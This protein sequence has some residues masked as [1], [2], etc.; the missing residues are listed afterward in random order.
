MGPLIPLFWTSGDVSYGF[1]NQSGQ[2]YSC[3]VE[4]YVLCIS[5][6]SALVWHLR[7]SW[8]PPWQLNH[9]LP[10]I[11]EQALVGLETG[12]CHAVAASRCETRQTLYLAMSAR[13][14][15]VNVGQNTSWRMSRV[16]KNEQKRIKKTFKIKFDESV[17]F[18]GEVSSFKSEGFEFTNL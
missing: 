17:H 16:K 8:W 9:S 10:H 12:I 2:P 1:Q 13:L 6:D 18:K 3:S 7:T 15:S 5:W 11:F 4:T 14:S